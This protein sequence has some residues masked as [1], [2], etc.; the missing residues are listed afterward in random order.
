VK[1]F[2]WNA[3]VLVFA[4][5]LL[6]TGWSE[7]LGDALRYDQ[8]SPF[9][10]YRDR[11][12]KAAA[13]KLAN[14][15]QLMDLYA[16]EQRAMGVRVVVKDDTTVVRADSGS[17]IVPSPAI[18]D[19]ELREIAGRVSG[20]QQAVEDRGAVFLYAAA[21]T[22]NN[23]E[24]VPKNVVDASK[25]NFERFLKLL[26]EKNVPVLDLTSIHPQYFRTDH[27]WL[28]ASGFDAA[29][30]ICER[31]SESNAFDYDA[32]LLDRSKWNAFDHPEF[33]LG[34]YGKKVGVA[35]GGRPDDF[36]LLTPQ[37]DTSLTETQPVKGLTREGTFEQAAL[38]TEYLKKDLYNVNP[39]VV[40]GGGDFRLQVLTNHLRPDGPKVMI[41]RDSFACAVT[42]FLALEC[43]ELHVCD[44][45]DFPFFV[46]DRL[47]LLQYMDEVEPDVVLVLYAGVNGFEK[48]NGMYNF[49]G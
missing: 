20:F 49:L 45:R 31:L 3:L 21:P 46:G 41:V 40:Y 18:P 25:S 10:T 26:G 22:K 1:R 37:F 9:E 24:T 8:L 14:H 35:F 48:A 5:A 19:E 12:D 6:T 39:Y 23:G 13:E 27:H 47:D 4:L 42:P 15:D 7:A 34:S 16:V 38:Y 29:R 17:L 11:V 2:N 43:S 33:F 32:S 28:P 30:A 44:L 36:T